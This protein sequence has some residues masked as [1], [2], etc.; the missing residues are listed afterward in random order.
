MV[1]ALSAG[2]VSST[3]VANS[4]TNTTAGGDGSAGGEGA[5]QAL[6]GGMVAPDAASNTAAGDAG[7][8]SAAAEQGET[9]ADAAQ[10]DPA[11]ELLLLC[12]ALPQAPIQMPAQTQ[13][14]PAALLSDVNSKKFAAEGLPLISAA[15]G[16]VAGTVEISSPAPANEAALLS[17]PAAALTSGVT[18]NKTANQR[19]LHWLSA[20]ART[21]LEKSAKTVESSVA[22]AVD[23]SASATG[24]S[25]NQADTVTGLPGL[26]AEVLNKLL[27]SAPM[28]AL[29]QGVH[30]D[31]RQAA[32]EADSDR[33]GV[34]NVAGALTAASLQPAATQLADDAAALD[35]PI[36]LQA[37]VGTQQWATELGNKLTLLASRETQSATLYLTPADLG[38]V[39]VRIETSQDQASVWFTAEHPDTRSALEQ[40]LPRLRELFTAQG[41]SLTDAGV[42]DNRSQ[43]QAAYTPEANPFTA[44]SYQDDEALADTATVRSLSLAL[45]D[46]YA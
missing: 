36:L 30:R 6:L 1:M 34:T 8:L 12:G 42:F 21:L 41:M 33:V 3:G 19:D 26:T 40:S 43:Q 7:L 11:M 2:S 16:A 22:S 31:A 44:D 5:F 29:M 46:A 45:L 37:S 17:G 39:Q 23:E 27:D 15:P 4:A 38:P 20:N 24:K 35:T 25:A 28:A 18:E 32:D 9:P 14:A 10:L 13:A